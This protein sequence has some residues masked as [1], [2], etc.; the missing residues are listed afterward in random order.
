MHSLWYILYSTLSLTMNATSMEDPR[1]L[2]LLCEIPDPVSGGFTINFS[3][4][5]KKF[6]SPLHLAAFAIADTVQ[7]CWQALKQG[8]SP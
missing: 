6:F 8:S 3:K 4:L 2:S 5:L 7:C 1:W